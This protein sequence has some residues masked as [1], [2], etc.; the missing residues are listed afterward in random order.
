M[1]MKLTFDV[2]GVGLDPYISCSEV[3]RLSAEPLLRRGT[4]ACKTRVKMITVFKTSGHVV[5]NNNSFRVPYNK[6]P[7]S[8]VFTV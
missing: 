5:H 1:L 3:S 4:E 6:I 7:D 2:K 8:S